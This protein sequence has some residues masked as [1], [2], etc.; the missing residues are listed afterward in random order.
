MTVVRPDRL[1]YAKLAA[2]RYF[3]Q[4]WPQK[5]LVIFNA[6]GERVGVPH[7]QWLLEIMLRPMPWHQMIALCRH[8]ANGQYCTVLY[9]D[10]WY[11]DHYLS[12]LMECADQE[13][14]VL[15]KRKLRYS[16]T[17]QKGYIVDDDRIACPLF[18]RL[19]PAQLGAHFSDFATQFHQVCHADGP[20]DCAVKFTQ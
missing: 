9:D 2:I 20:L 10:T 18:P 19:H 11:G 14:L 4:D 16:V 5:H 3:R 7:K 1:A 15:L 6:T 8:N 13:T 17:E 12:T